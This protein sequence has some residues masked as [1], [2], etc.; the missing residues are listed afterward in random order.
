MLFCSRN[1]LPVRIDLPDGDTRHAVCSLRSN[2]GMRQIKRNAAAGNLG[3]MDTI[4]A[5]PWGSICNGNDFTACLQQLKADD[6]S[7]I[8][9][10]Q[11]QNPLARHCAMQ[12]H[13]G[14]SCTCSNDTRQRP[15]RKC[16]HVFAC[17]RCNQNRI[18]FDMLDFIANLYSYFFF[19]KDSDDNGIQYNGNTQCSGFCQQFFTDMKPSD[20]GFVLFRAENL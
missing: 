12:I 10:T 14:L 3:S 19:R 18:T 15:A 20:F 5:N 1:Y 17:T 11:H 2:N 8:P 4:S 16:H 6:Q 13:H 9:R 7:N